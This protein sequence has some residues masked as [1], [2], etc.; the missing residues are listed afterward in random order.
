[1]GDSYV[2]F[3]WLHLSDI[4]FSET[5]GFN[6][7][8]LR[9]SLLKYLKELREQYDCVVFSGDYRYAPDKITNV[10]EV[11]TYINKLLENTGLSNDKI[12]IVPGN[13]DLK[14]STAR[15]ALAEEA[16]KNYNSEDGKIDSSI[17]NILIG[18]DTFGFFNNIK[19]KI[20]KN[21]DVVYLEGN[22]HSIINMQ[23]CYLLALNTA[24]IA[25]GGKSDKNK[26]IIGSDYVLK[27]IDQIRDNPK[28]II[29]VGHHGFDW[30]KEEEK[31]EML[32]LFK[33]EGIKLYLCGHSHVYSSQQFTGGITQIT[34][35]SIKQE[36]KKNNDENNDINADAAFSIGQLYSDGK[37]SIGFYE[38][39][40]RYKKWRKDDTP[41]ENSVFDGLYNIPEEYEF[42]PEMSRIEKVS[43]PFT[44]LKLVP[45]D[46]TTPREGIM[47][48]WGKTGYDKAVESIT[49]NTRLKGS[50]HPDD[51]S[52]SAYT[53]STSIGCILSAM[54]CSCK[55]C[56][57]GRN[58]FT[59][60]LTAEDIALQSIF[61]TLYDKEYCR[62][63][64]E[65][66]DHKR[67]FAYMGQG[68]PGYHYDVVKKA[69]LLNDIA[70]KKLGQTV[71]RYI[72]S[73]FG[74]TDFLSSLIMDMKNEVFKN[75]ISLH[76]SLHLIGE[77]RDNLMPINKHYDYRDFIKLCKK[78]HQLTQ[79]KIGV[80]VLL[81]SDY[82]TNDAQHKF[83]LTK[84][85]L[86]RILKELD[87]D[88]FRIDLC[89]LNKTNT[90]RN[91]KWEET[92][93]EYYEFVKSQGF[94]VKIFQSFGGEFQSGCGML[95]SNTDRAL[96]VGDNTVRA[97]NAA[98]RLLQEVKK[99]FESIY[100]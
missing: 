87:K 41:L 34:V 53:I 98:V 39:N 28:P 18:D 62:D 58:E 16:L 38:W 86:T 61:M 81:F 4:H 26:L 72:I 11:T 2:I 74:N 21:K 7:S 35:G 97:F 77:D 13:H 96:D 75:K 46:T 92:E 71:S 73:T 79:E 14:K 9:S 50:K 68:E 55:F 37:V 67:E 64:S 83:D 65:V 29:A 24:L 36:I 33:Q 70:M 12:V 32:L 51:L 59:T 48:I 84:D 44:I 82:R 31:N 22:P 3:K 69:I 45:F 5:A 54:N 93:N 42:E 27:L 20:A 15:K 80:A 56:E 95:S 1:M 63:H 90:G 76:F 40:R 19:T 99:E 94:D 85:K 25:N 57:T 49:F 8:R 6:T 30:F 43:H 66:R 91:N 88:M 47:Y 52:T 89:K 17:L 10:E 78:Y 100:L 23:K 60:P